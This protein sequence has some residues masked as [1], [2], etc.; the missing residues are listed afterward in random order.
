MLD[1]VFSRAIGIDV[2]QNLLVCNARIYQD[3]HWIN[4]MQ[5]FGAYQ[6][7]L[8]AMTAWCQQYSPETILMESTG[9]YWK[10]VFKSLERANLNPS[11][12][13]ARQVRGMVGKKT[14]MN[15]AQWLSKIA[16]LG[17]FT[18]SYI[19]DEKW[20]DLRSTSRG[21]SKLI[22]SRQAYK[23]RENKVFVEAGYRLHSV[24][25]DTFGRS[26][27]IAKDGILAG[28]SA[29]EIVKDLNS[30]R[31]KASK[32]ELI[33]A[34]QGEL[35]EEHRILIEAYREVIK[36]LDDKID[37][38]TNYLISEV[39][40][41]ENRNFM[42]LQTIPGF[43]KL[44]AAVFLIE[45]GGRNFLDA[46][47]NEERFASWLGVCPGNNESAGKRKSGRSRKGNIYLR[48]ILCEA[49]QAAARTKGTTFQSKYNSLSIRLGR[50]RSI[51]AIAHKLTRVAYKILAKQEPYIERHVDYQKLSTKKNAP[52]W[53][54]NLMRYNEEWDVV[55]RN[56]KT[57][58]VLST[59]KIQA[60][61]QA[62]KA[63]AKG[64]F[65][66]LVNSK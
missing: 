18:P 31:L 55:A 10:S 38:L 9:V 16:T 36:T 40:K 14:D 29:E 62:K 51:F 34:L 58:E 48:R 47:A 54:K 24:F 52:R 57:G 1:A 5:T 50:K 11:V 66:S 46:F 22:A 44:S 37:S 30:K 8:D 27:Q 33:N 28:K 4:D 2:H 23:N 42:L 65:R 19:P 15:D 7:D 3:G 26:A 12:V 56:R 45:V 21:L 20:R 25:S 59:D 32:E 35:H 49:A 39:Q 63:A 6:V 17:T 13:N 61:E 60:A 41:L 64:E 53:L 43:D